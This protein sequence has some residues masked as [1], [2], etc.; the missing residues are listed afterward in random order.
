MWS[1][2]STESGGHGAGPTGTFTFVPEVV[3]AV[4][5]NAAQTGTP[6]PPVLAAGGITDGRQVCSCLSS[7]I[8]QHHSSPLAAV[9]G[10]PIS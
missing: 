8:C 4:A 5:G 10:H 7:Q 2:Q 6:A 3:D 9:L 1:F